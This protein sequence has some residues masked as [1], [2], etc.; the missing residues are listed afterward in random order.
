MNRHYDMQTI[1][2]MD[3][4][5]KPRAATSQARATTRLVTIEVTDAHVLA[6]AKAG[7]LPEP[8]ADPADLAIA[9][10]IALDVLVEDMEVGADAE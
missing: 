3:R 9:V 6:L 8:T 2:I 1:E 7:C 10:E 5:T 4:A